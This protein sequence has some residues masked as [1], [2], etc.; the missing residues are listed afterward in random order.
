MTD[1]QKHHEARIHIDREEFFSPD[2]TTGS[3]LYEL[4]GIGEH[5][6]LYRE[7]QGDNEDE[8][9]AKDVSSVDLK[10]D[11]HFY[12]QKAIIVVV[13]G[14][15]KETSETRLSFREVVILAFGG[16]Q[17]GPNIMFTIVYRK[18]PPQNPK[19]TL[20]KGQSVKAKDGM[21]FD[22]TTTDRS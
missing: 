11:D 13:N 19:G 17:E 18:G 2:P 1:V 16:V 8:L 5:R 10:Q 12:S 3:A 15:R 9:I 22:V 4:G 7:A 21:I 6:E 20:L 14:E